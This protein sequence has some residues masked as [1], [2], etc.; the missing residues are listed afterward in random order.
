MV[1]NPRIAVAKRRVSSI[2]CRLQDQL[3]HPGSSL[4]GRKE[5]PAGQDKFIRARTVAIYTIYGDKCGLLKLTTQKPEAHT[6]PGEQSNSAVPRG[7]VVFGFHALRSTLSVG[8]RRSPESEG[9][10]VRSGVSGS[11]SPGSHGSDR[12]HEAA[13]FVKRGWDTRLAFV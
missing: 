6:Y 7:L 9:G 11:R 10:A 5:L 4:F 2:H 13:W 1:I 3:A 12:I 8:G